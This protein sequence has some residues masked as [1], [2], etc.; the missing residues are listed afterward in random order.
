M[1][2]FVNHKAMMVVA[3]PLLIVVNVFAVDKG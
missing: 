2:R 3:L 1:K